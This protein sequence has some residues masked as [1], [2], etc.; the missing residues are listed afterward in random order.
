MGEDTKIDFNGTI[1]LTILVDECN[2]LDCAISST[3]TQLNFR[4]VHTRPMGTSYP[5]RKLISDS[6]KQWA[7]SNER[8]P[9]ESQA[10]SSYLILHL[11][12]FD[13]LVQLIFQFFIVFLLALGCQH[14]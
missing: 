1:Y 14:K 6:T 8:T 10:I 13:R 2:R 5:E 11:K 4:L 12:G 9:M 3:D 7:K